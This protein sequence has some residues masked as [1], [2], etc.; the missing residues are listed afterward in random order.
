MMDPTIEPSNTKACSPRVFDIY[1]GI[2][3]LIRAA[4]IFHLNAV[5]MLLFTTK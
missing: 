5:S 4:M 1:F 2:I 3:V